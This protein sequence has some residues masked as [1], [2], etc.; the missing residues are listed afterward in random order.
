MPPIRV[1]DAMYTKRDSKTL[2]ARMRVD[3][4]GRIPVV[5]SDLYFLCDKWVGGGGQVLRFWESLLLGVCINSANVRFSNGYFPEWKGNG[6]LSTATFE[7][8]DQS[9]WCVMQYKPFLCKFN[10]LKKLVKNISSKKKTPIV[11]IMYSFSSKL[12][13]ISG[14]H[15]DKWNHP[16]EALPKISTFWASPKVGFLKFLANL[17]NLYFTN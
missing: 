2:R 7:L 1:V 5:A 16:W 14:H 12:W 8:S 6:S 9:S 13:E 4:V 17:N 3:F 10:R 15:H 11:F